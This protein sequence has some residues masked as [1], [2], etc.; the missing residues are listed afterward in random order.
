MQLRED[1]AEDLVFVQGHG[2][3]NRY[4]VGSRGRLLMVVR[5]IYDDGTLTLRVFGNGRRPASSRDLGESR[6]GAGWPDVV[7]GAGLSRSFEVADY[8]G[9]QDSMIYYLDDE[10]MVSGPLHGDRRL[11][12]FTDTGRYDMEEVATAPWPE[13]LYPTTSDN[14][15]PTWWLH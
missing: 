8:D 15:P 10:H 5:Y 9:F 6:P 1:Y 13:G 11:Y 4:L 12:S 2:M 7:P 3:M 14:A